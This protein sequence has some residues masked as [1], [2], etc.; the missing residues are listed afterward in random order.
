MRKIFLFAV[1]VLIAAAFAW[2][3]SDVN[4]QTSAKPKIVHMVKP[5]Y[6]PEA[7]AAKITG[8]VQV[9]V[10]I[11]P[12]GSVKVLSATGPEQLQA[13]ASAAVA[14]WQ[15]EPVLLNGKPVTAKADVTVNFA[16]AKDKK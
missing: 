15:Y 8:A 3:G 11:Q 9:K 16:L 10:E 13:A 4:I 14:Q 5:E 6:P 12:D 7:K 1:I 2:A